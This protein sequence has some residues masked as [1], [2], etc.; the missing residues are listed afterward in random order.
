MSK[1]VKNTHNIRVVKAWDNLFSS[2][3][4]YNVELSIVLDNRLEYQHKK[5]TNVQLWNFIYKTRNFI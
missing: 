5:Q 2:L 4:A 3:I 1:W